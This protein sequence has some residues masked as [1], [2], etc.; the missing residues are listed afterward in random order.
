[1]RHL[2]AVISKAPGGAIP[3]HYQ[4]V[5]S[6]VFGYTDFIV[7]KDS[8]EPARYKPKIMLSDSSCCF[9]TRSTYANSIFLEATFLASLKSGNPILFAANSRFPSSRNQTFC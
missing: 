6:N 2:K 5:P 3:L 1:M 8:V 7:Q 4:G 9:L